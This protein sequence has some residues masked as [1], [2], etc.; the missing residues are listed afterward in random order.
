MAEWLG[1]GL[2]NLVR[3]FESACRLFTV[4]REQIYSDQRFTIIDRFLKIN[5]S[6]FTDTLITV[7]LICRVRLG[8]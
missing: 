2:Q 6:L 7:L 4:N 5:C 8:V 3:R 1:R